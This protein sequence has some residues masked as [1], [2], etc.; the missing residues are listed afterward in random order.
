MIREY[1]Q[2]F[3]K[4]RY[5]KMYGTNL[6][7]FSKATSLDFFECEDWTKIKKLYVYDDSVLVV[8]FK[9]HTRELLLG[10]EMQFLL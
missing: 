4:P 9:H 5:S 8:T 6:H 3:S 1:Q 2:V 7:V 10:A